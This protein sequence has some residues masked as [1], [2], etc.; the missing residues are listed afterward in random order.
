[1]DVPLFDKCINYISRN[2]TVVQVEDLVNLQPEKHKNKFATITLDDGYKDNIIYAA[3]I[4]DKYK[5]KVSFY[6]VTDCVEKNIPTWTHVLEYLFQYS[7]KTK[8][9]LGFGFLPEKFRISE[10]RNSV[11]KIYYAENLI[12][13]IKTL[14]HEERN[15]IIDTVTRTFDDVEIPGLMM[16]WKDIKELSGHGHIIGSHTCTHSI[17]THIKDEAELKRE[18]TESGNII[19]KNVGYFPST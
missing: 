11:E 8:I 17:L 12:P 7:G 14:T 16:D 15:L 13:F 10:F 3:P 1:M 18:L 5:V 6:V 19:M 4:L 2:Y 9:D